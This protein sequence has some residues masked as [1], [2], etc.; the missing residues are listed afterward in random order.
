LLVGLVVQAMGAIKF[1]RWM[2]LLTVGTFA[3]AYPLMYFAQ[4]YIPLWVA[5]ISSGAVCIVIIGLRAMTLLGAWRAA[6]GVVLPGV[7]IMGLT[8]SSAIWPSLQ[9][10][11]LTCLSLMF[12]I[13]AMLL[14]P[15]IVAHTVYNVLLDY[16]WYHWVNSTT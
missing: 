6:S 13:V 9:G 10:I 4:E 7:I 12:F 3:G 2:L 1:D 16:E 5:I 15:K 11:L 8:L 14:M